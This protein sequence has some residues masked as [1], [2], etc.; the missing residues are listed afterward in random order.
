V[1]NLDASALYVLGEDR[2]DYLCWVHSLKSGMSIAEFVTSP[3]KVT[4]I[5]TVEELSVQEQEI[6]A[7]IQELQRQLWEVINIIA[8]L[9]ISTAQVESC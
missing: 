8:M 2:T 5:T 3:T 6:R 1:H 7:Q 9:P 4:A